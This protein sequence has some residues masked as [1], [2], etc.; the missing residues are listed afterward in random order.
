MNYTMIKTP[1]VLDGS[2][3]LIDHINIIE[4]IC[5]DA[6][7]KKLENKSKRVAIDVG[8]CEGLWSLNL[9]Q[10]FDKV[11]A[12]EPNV[13]MVEIFSRHMPDHVHVN[14][15]GLSDEQETY[16]MITFTHNVGMSMRRESKEKRDQ[17]AI[18]GSIE[19]HMKAMGSKTRTFMGTSKPL[20][21]EYHEIV[22]FIKIDA[23]GD[24][25][26]VIEGAWETIKRCRPLIF[27][28]AEQEYNGLESLGYQSESIP[29][30]LHD[31]RNFSTYMYYAP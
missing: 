28:D 17:G 15:Y 25:H 8:F 12:Y 7:M 4:T 2:P 18:G 24:D 13:D 27:I 31:N 29:I 10:Y 14:D 22:D 20:D 5:F 3:T 9:S 30:T 21:E 26:K 11:H 6:V 1:F 16:E 23:E 19:E